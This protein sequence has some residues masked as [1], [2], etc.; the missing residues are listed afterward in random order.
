M[1]Y[2]NSLSS[3]DNGPSSLSPTRKWSDALPANG[4]NSDSRNCASN[5]FPPLTS[6]SHKGS[7]GR[8]AILGGSEK[9]TG[10]PYYAAQSALNCGID[11]ATIFCAKEAA[12]PIKCY[13]PELMVQSVYSIEA[14]DALLAE[15]NKLLEELEQCKQSNAVMTNEENEIELLQTMEKLEHSEEKQH[16]LIQN[17]WQKKDNNDS[18]EILA[19]RLAKMQVLEGQLQSLKER[20][21]VEVGGIADVVTA[22]F[23]TLHALCVGPGLG[24]H[25]LVFSAVEKVLRKAV[26]AKLILVLDADA[27]FMLSLEEYRSL[28]VEL[29][30]Y[31]RCVMTPNL[32]E[33]RRLNDAISSGESLETSEGN[34]VGIQH[35]NI[36][37]QK[38]GVD[39]IMQG[40][41]TMQCEEEGGLKR[42]GGIGDVLAGTISAFMAWNAILEKD[43]SPDAGDGGLA[44]GEQQQQQRLFAS[45]TACAAVKKATKAAF[46][47]KRRA[48]SAMDVVGEIGEVIAGMEGGL[49]LELC[50]KEEM[51][52]PKSLQE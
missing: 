18:I 48:M 6:S 37:V 34:D 23:P 42:S 15:E 16:L 45:W 8:I 9:Y 26:E 5:L 14:L 40:D 11:L 10:A 29:S 47:K 30:G 7:H 2:L 44:N 39:T 50:S 1:S 28:F 41:S 46:Q 3:D 20:Q 12:V 22:M 35:A 49:K 36:I 51:Q 19:D 25:P 13:S 21:E 32:M 17:E 52:Q 38:G 27:L 43:A 4:A 33:M 24:R 31:E